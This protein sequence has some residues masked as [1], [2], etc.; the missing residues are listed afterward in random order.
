MTNRNFKKLAPIALILAGVVLGTLGGEL[1]KLRSAYA[2]N[3]QQQGDQPAPESILNAGEQR[4]QLNDKMVEV[5]AHLNKI[6]AKLN[7]GIS[8]KVTE[9]PPVVMKDAV[10]K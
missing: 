1:T 7:T 9:M 10:P 8:V 6:E 4:K 3:R 5:I 2:D